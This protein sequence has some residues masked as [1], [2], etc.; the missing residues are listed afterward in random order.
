MI[1]HLLDKAVTA[2]SWI[3]GIL[4][5]ATLAVLIAYL[6]YQGGAGIN[7]TLIFGGT[8]PLKAILLQQPVLDGLFPA[9]AGTLSL[10]ILSV[11]LALPVGLAAGIY[12]AE[13]ATGR[14]KSFFGFILDILAG[15]PSIV[16]GLFGFSG[17][18]FLHHHF[19]AQ[20]F[21]CLLI[22]AVSL[23]FLVMPYLVG[24][25]KAALNDIPRSIRDTA[26][27]LGASKLQNIRFVLLP[28]CLPGIV[29]GVVLSIGRCAEDTAVIMLT[30][31]VATAGIPKSIWSSYEALPFYIFYISSQYTNPRELASGYGAAILLLGVCICLYLV[32]FFIRNRLIIRYRIDV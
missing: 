27:A 28:H 4:L 15:I 11:V 10:V 25:T 2:F 20:I 31:V 16:V 12:M 13:Y 9:I 17:A 3:C 1:P 21:P 5:M 22:S 23:A 14:L 8:E 24:S 19:S 18:I 26:P 29:S 32:A 6:L 7:S 30:G